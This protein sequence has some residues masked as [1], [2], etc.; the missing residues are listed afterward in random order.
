MSDIGKPNAINS[1]KPTAFSD[2]KSQVTEEKLR[3]V[4]DLYE[5]HFIREMVKQMR[6]TVHEGGFI[7]QNNAEKIFRDQLDDQYSDQWGKAG[8]IGLSDLIYNQLIEKYGPAVGLKQVIEKPQ[9]PISLDQKSV[10]AGITSPTTS[11]SSPETS[12]ATFKFQTSEGEKSELKNP[13][14]GKLLDKKY[15]EMDQMQYHIKHDNG[16]ESYIL[17]RGTGLGSEHK[18]SLG[19]K[20]EA[21]EQIGWV[22][23][24]SPLFWTVK[25]NVSE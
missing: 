24:A 5:N 11:S 19:D 22:S 3:Q 4:S 8:G 20:I 23:S 21:G 10:F 9:G 25:P 15:L 14:A 7:K 12:A 1:I 18:L 16:L 2:K 6:S 17:T 13:W